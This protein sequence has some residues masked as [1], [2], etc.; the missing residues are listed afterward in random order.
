VLLNF[1]LLLLWQGCQEYPDS[2]VCFGHIQGHPDNQLVHVKRL[3][4][5]C[6]N[7]QSLS[8]Y[9]NAGNDICIDVK[10]D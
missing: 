7:K 8:E 3:Q 9:A 5:R 2:A 6:R 1:D 10:R 4:V